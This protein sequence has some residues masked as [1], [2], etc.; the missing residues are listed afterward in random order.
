MK[1]IIPTI[2]LTAVLLTACSSRSYA[3]V[4]S[5]EF[6]V[7]A[8]YKTGDFSYNCEISRHNEVVTIT[9][10]SGYAKGTSISFDGS[11]VT[12]KRGSMEK[13]IQ[14]DIIKSDNP[15]MMIYQVFRYLEK[16]DQLDVKRIDN[17][18]QYTGETDFGTFVL[19]QNDDNSLASLSL[20]DRN[21]EITFCSI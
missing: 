11:G 2:L 8:V 6:D 17:T 1:K 5:T 10:M 7:M 19:V 4:I 14:A 13:T 18:Y 16:N 3:P 21:V 20:P 9:S 12:F 15:A